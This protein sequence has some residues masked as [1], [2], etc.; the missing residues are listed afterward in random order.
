MTS[1]AQA[2]RLNANWVNSTVWLDGSM[3]M[4]GNGIVVTMGSLVS[5][6]INTGVTTTAN[7]QWTSTAATTDVAGNSTTVSTVTETG[8]T[9]RDF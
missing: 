8:A 7:L 4:S 9:D 2:L 6:T 5:G 3:T 1:A